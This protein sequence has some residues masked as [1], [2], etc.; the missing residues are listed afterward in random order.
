M[1][2][3]GRYYMVV[4]T[5][6]NRRDISVEIY[7]DMEQWAE[8]YDDDGPQVAEFYGRASGAAWNIPLADA[9]DLLKRA[10]DELNRRPRK[11]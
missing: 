7:I 6:D 10:S 9:L 11:K 3:Q 1:Y 2:K 4:G 8:V 5:P